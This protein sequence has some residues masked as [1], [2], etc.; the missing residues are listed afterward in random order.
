MSGMMMIIMIKK[1]IM[2]K[3]VE[4]G[5]LINYLKDYCNCQRQIH[6]QILGCIVLG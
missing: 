3:K 1:L 5:N 2:S 6:K 4:N